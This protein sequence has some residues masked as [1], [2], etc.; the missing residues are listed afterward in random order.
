MGNVTQASGIWTPD[1]DDT[2]DPEVWSAVMSQSL[3]DG[4]GIRMG[5]QEARV[6][7][8][9]TTPVPF[10]VDSRTGGPAYVPVPLTVGGVTNVRLPDPDYAGGNHA[11][12]IKM[13][14]NVAIVET[15]GLYS[16][17]GQISLV[18]G[19]ANPVHSW[20]FFGTI[21][22]SIFGLPAYGSTTVNSFVGG[23]VFDTRQLVAGDR[24]G[25]TIGVGTDHI[26]S[27]LVQDA[28]LSVILHYAT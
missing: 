16:M 9:A 1:E 15:S 20:D 22:G 24:I 14:S 21:N 17:T 5:K 25:L 8:R 12:G 27:F 13:E 3:E 6:G 26:G 18:G 7:L 28:L 4:L 11:T 10:T 2:V 23:Y 19:A